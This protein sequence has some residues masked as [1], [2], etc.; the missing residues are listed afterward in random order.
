MPLNVETK[1][2]VL[3]EL[4]FSPKISLASLSL[5][6]SPFFLMNNSSK[7][8]TTSS[9]DP[10]YFFPALSSEIIMLSP[11]L[12]SN[13]LDSKKIPE[14][15]IFTYSITFSSVC[16]IGLSTFNKSSNVTP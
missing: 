4:S 9:S 10:S 7:F 12:S 2:L 16:S 13:K 5:I 8:L 14:L 15:V 6:F 11:L 1:F 3:I